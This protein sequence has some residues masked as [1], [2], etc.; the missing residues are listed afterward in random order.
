M[1]TDIIQE[2]VIKTFTI[3]LVMKNGVNILQIWDNITK[4]VSYCAQ[5][6]VCNGYDPSISF[7]PA[8][9]TNYARFINVSLSLNDKSTTNS[10]E[11]IPI[12]AFGGLIALSILVMILI[13]IAIFIIYKWKT[14]SLQTERI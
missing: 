1:L 11:N 10:I 3:I 13:G 4:D 6:S 2:F 9:M 7:S 14:A 12:V 8:A 5:K